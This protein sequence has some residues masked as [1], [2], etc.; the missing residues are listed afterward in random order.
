MKVAI[1]DRSQYWTA[2]RRARQ[3]EQKRLLFAAHP[4]KHPNRILANNRSK[5]SYPERRMY[6]WLSSEGVQFE[7]NAWTGRYWVDFRIRKLCV[8]VDGA[9]WHDS[10]RDTVRDEWLRSFGNV[11]VR[12]PARDVIRYGPQA[13]LDRVLEARCVT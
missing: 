9:R 3:S 12:V 11:V 4:E 6:E 8:E 10:T 2:E 7:H 13:A 5:M 1:Y